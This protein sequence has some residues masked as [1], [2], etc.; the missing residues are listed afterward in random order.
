MTLQ[1]IYDLGI[2]M[3]IK[4]DPRGEDEVKK[5]LQRLKKEYEELPSKK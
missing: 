5:F 2:S 4:A 3:A 1:Q